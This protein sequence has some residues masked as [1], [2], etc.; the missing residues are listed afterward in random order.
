V[1]G[2]GVLYF[3]RTYTATASGSTTRR[4]RCVGCSR[5][6]EYTIAREVAGGGH[7]V[8]MLNNAGAAASAQERARANLVRTLDEAIEPVHCPTCGIFQPKMVQVLRKRHGKHYD[9]NKY[10]SER[11]AIPAESAWR[12]ARAVNTKAAYVRFVEVWPTLDWQAKKQIKEL[13]FPPHVRKFVSGLLWF[14][15]TSLVLFAAG[16]G[17]SGAFGIRFEEVLREFLA[18]L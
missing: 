9:P 1:S 11:I 8:F 6:F 13:R 14:G 3:Y 2:G 4:E 7:S 12:T 5:I 18:K 17:A 10:A 16:V 15:W